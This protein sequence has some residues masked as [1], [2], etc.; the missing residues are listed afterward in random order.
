MNLHQFIDFNDKCPVCNKELTL[1]AS[2][3][4]SALWKSNIISPGRYEFE[5]FRMKKEELG[6]DHMI[7]DINK[8]DVNL[9]FSTPQLKNESKSWELFFFKCCG[10]G[11]DFENIFSDNKFDYDI[12]LY[13]TC[14]YQ[15]SSQYEFQQND[16]EWKLENVLHSLPLINRD[17]TF[18]FK[19]IN[20]DKLEKVYVLNLD[21]EDEHTKL[22]HYTIT[23]EQKED[24]DFEPNIFEKND[25][26]LLRSR[27]DLSLEARDQLISRFDGWI[28][29]S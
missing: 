3:F 4:K 1:F 17:E 19:K 18:V 28:L 26:P 7:L 29:L 24:K 27:P 8:N 15:S 5:Q 21:Y 22:W 20:E 16:G 11:D 12:N 9:K 13:E 25:L 14:Y 23:P 10:G 6:N 2:V